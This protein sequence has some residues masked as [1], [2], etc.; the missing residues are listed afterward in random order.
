MNIFKKFFIATI[1]LSISNSTIFSKTTS[2][3]LKTPDS[4]E[5]LRA[6]MIS[7]TGIDPKTGQKTGGQRFEI[8]TT[9][10]KKDASK[11]N[12]EYI[13]AKG[14]MVGGAN[15]KLSTSNVDGSMIDGILYLKYDPETRGLGFSLTKSLDKDNASIFSRR[16]IL[17]GYDKLFFGN[18]IVLQTEDIQKKEIK[19]HASIAI[20]PKT[21]KKASEE[22]YY[23]LKL[24]NTKKYLAVSWPT[25]HRKLKVSDLHIFTTTNKNKATKFNL[26]NTTE[27]GLIG[28][29]K[30][31]I[32]Y[33]KEGL[34]FDVNAPFYLKFLHKD[35][36]DKGCFVFT[37]NPV[38]ATKF[39]TRVT[40]EDFDNLYVADTVVLE[41]E[42]I[43]NQEQKKLGVKTQIIPEPR[44]F[45]VTAIVN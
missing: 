37:K 28:T 30:W 38:E 26:K 20:I 15:Y 11:F 39:S 19:K 43:E 8:F 44:P 4:G 13:P 23:H 40:F 1:F 12:L 32:T 17:D 7:W 41:R 6:A 22:N 21:A 10:D 9:A 45:D 5:Y 29:S 18:K 35:K 27:L 34:Q 42:P 14:F 25:V 2:V 33:N 3:Y 36:I 31:L 16:A 24:P